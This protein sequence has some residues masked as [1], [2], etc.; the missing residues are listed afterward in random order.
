M[1]GYVVYDNINFADRTR[2]EEI[3]HRA[4]FHSFTNAAWV[5]CNDIPEGG[6]TQD[7]HNP[8]HPLSIRDVMLSDGI[9]N[10]GSFD[11]DLSRFFIVEAIERL[12]GNAVKNLF[13]NCADQKPQFPVIDRRP[14]TRTE[15]WQ[16]AGITAN[17]G[18]IEGTYA[19]HDDIFLQQ[20][21][22]TKAEQPGLED[23]FTNRLF[24]AY[25]DQ[26]TTH[27]IRSVQHEQRHAGLAYDRR[28]WMMGVPAWFH[29]QYN[30]LLTIVRTHW[31]P[32]G[33][34]TEHHCVSHDATLWN[35]TQTSRD[36]VKYH[37]MEPIVAQGFTARV[38]A[39]FYSCL[40]SRGLG[41]IR[42]EQHG[43]KEDLEGAIA[44][45]T[46]D[47]FLEI[48]EEVRQHAF[49]RQAWENDNPDVDFRTMCRYLQEVEML[50]T[51]RKAIKYADVG[52]LRRMVDPLIIFFTGAGQSNYSREMLYYRWLL[53]PAN[54]PTLQYAILAAG[55]VNWRGYQ[56]ASKPIDLALEHLNSACKID[57]RNSKNSTR[58]VGVIFQRVALCNTWLRVLREK[59][60]DQYG[61]L[62]TGSHSTSTATADMFLLAWQTHYQGLGLPRSA[63]SL[64]HQTMFDSAD[65]RS[66]GVRQL[67]SV[68]ARHNAENVRQSAIGA[69]LPAVDD[70]G[71][72]D[73]SEFADIVHAGFDDV[74]DP[75]LIATSVIDEIDLT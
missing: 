36:N 33:K 53:S 32:V 54:T 49:T 9:Q 26:L 44:Q 34:Q 61:E 1:Q 29:I 72:V 40:Q 4:Q 11:T 60:E 56:G 20:L 58:D 31:K 17:E 3:G 15:F 45:L 6:L 25:G 16:L 8:S 69:V 12:H 52:I 59:L 75:T 24:L 70:L 30:L 65:I 42:N 63:S 14:G 73:I 27:H 10:T 37:L 2:H 67:G 22:Y 62:M 18:T 71:F 46:P 64:S 39:I 47:L 48:V 23:D 21:G 74:D 41:T 7:M 19:V 38:V 50:L 13:K 66:L 35:R 5:I 28:Q 68:I 43:R 55:L 51:I 57:L